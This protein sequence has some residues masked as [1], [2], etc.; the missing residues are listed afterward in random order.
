M[1]YLDAPIGPIGGLMI[2]RDHENPNLFFYVPER[3]RLARNDGVP[4]FVFLTYRRDITDNPDFNE[5]ED[6]LGGGF[7]SFTVDLSVDERRLKSIKRELRD[8]AENSGEIQLAPIQFRKGSVRLSIAENEPEGEAPPTP[9]EE[10]R[11]FRLYEKIYGATKPSL[12]GN[13]RATF[14]LLVDREMATLLEAGMRTGVSPIGVIYD[15]EF[16]GLRPAFNVKVTA[17]YKRIYNHLET[18]FGARG[19]IYAVSLAAEIAAAFQKLRD[20]GAIKVEVMHFTDDEDL[21][22]Q[23]TAAFDWFKTQLLNDFFNSALQ[24]PSFMTRQPGSG[25]LLGQLQ[26]LLGPLSRPQEGSSSTPERGAPATEAPTSAEPPTGMGSGVTSSRAASQA[27]SGGG[28]AGG[29]GGASDMSPFQVAFSLK[30]YRQEE[31]KKRTFE[32]SM[33]AAVAREAAPQ[34]LFSTVLDGLDLDRAIKRVDLDDDFFDRIRVNVSMGEDLE[35][36]QISAVAVNLEYPAEREPGVDADHTA[37]FLFRPGEM[38]SHVFTTFLNDARERDYRYKMDVTFS[39]NSEWEG[40]DSQVSTGWIAASESELV[41]SPLDQ[42]ELLDIQ[43]S[44]GDLDSEE[45][46]QAEVKLVYSDP[47]HDFETEKTL[48]L[49][50]GE[51]AQNWKLRLGDDASRQFQY[52]VRYFLKSGNLRYE[53]DFVTT[54]DPTVIVNEPF[55]GENSVRLMPLLDA[56]TLLEAVVDLEYEEQSTGYRREFQELIDAT[57]AGNRKSLKF[58]TLD[59]DSGSMS[60]ETTVVRSDGSVFESGKKKL[61]TSVAIISDGSG[62]VHRIKVRLPSPSLGTLVALKI[63]LTGPGE[64][65]DSE[66]VLFTPSQL[67]EKMVALVQSGTGSPFAYT[68]KV[69]G[70]DGRGNEVPGQSKQSADRVLI[71]PMPDVP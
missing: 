54:E 27:A 34:G 41:L 3:P 65:P 59:S 42:L 37:G 46:Q 18:E 22:A 47:E 25:G 52:K 1:L 62:E 15:L 24:P 68:F 67:E 12:F 26:N 33:Q 45:I 19:Q 16:L 13:N 55:T 43:V 11:G 44:L 2:Y 64:D 7:L 70:Y 69:T 9:A 31:L 6:S 61:D 28:G 56:D 35:A 20:E 29:G 32:Y 49:K 53:T 71:V 38:D 60:V 14:S 48:L 30:M 5:A 51:G 10:Q 23:A 63:E 21:R 50:P 36:A 66:S 57:N 39:P 4:E 40:R 17:E 58:P 8:F